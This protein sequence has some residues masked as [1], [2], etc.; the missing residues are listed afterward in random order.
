MV[1]Q[2]L[3]KF[4]ERKRTYNSEGKCLYISNESFKNNLWVI[5]EKVSYTYDN[6]GNELTMLDSYFS[7]G[8][9]YEYGK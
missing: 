1:K 6:S 4:L 7:G 5:E 9:L 3:G 2:F 8:L